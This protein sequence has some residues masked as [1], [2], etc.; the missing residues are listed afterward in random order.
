M[1]EA[2]WNKLPKSQKQDIVEIQRRGQDWSG[3][4]PVYDFPGEAFLSPTP[5][6]FAQLQVKLG[7]DNPEAAPLLRRISLHFDDALVS[8]GVTSRILPRQAGF[9]SPQTFTYVL[10]PTF[11]FGDEGFDRIRIQVPAPV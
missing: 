7:N 3:W 11:R 2:Q 8:G 9:D 5:R 1:S 6:K 10:T 4:G